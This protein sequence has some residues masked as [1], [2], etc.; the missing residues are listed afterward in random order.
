[1]L[2]WGT[3]VCLQDR[4]GVY[5]QLVSGWSGLILWLCVWT[6][7]GSIWFFLVFFVNITFSIRQMERYN[8]R[9][10]FYIHLAIVDYIFVPISF[11][12]FVLCLVLWKSEIYVGT[13][14]KAEEFFYVSMC[15]WETHL[16]IESH[17]L[18][19]TMEIDLVP[20]GLE[21]LQNQI[22]YHSS[23]QIPLL[24]GFPQSSSF[25]TH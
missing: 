14:Y 4:N 13:V 16:H 12:W 8:V 17:R 18:V 23:G 20:S 9:D 21:H 10:I 15:N 22:Q 6:C 5:S 2:S 19:E 11:R 3:S 7:N 1:M 25:L 24:L